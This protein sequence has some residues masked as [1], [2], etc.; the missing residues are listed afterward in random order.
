[1]TATDKIHDV[2]T[3]NAQVVGRLYQLGHTPAQRQQLALVAQTIMEN[4]TL[5]AHILTEIDGSE[6]L[7]DIGE[8]SDA[9]APPA[10]PPAAPPA[11]KGKGVHP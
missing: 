4:N 1:M 8:A 7:E 9:S 6:V 2:L 5:I 11:K 3:N 10:T